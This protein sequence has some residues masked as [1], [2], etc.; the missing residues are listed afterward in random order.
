MSAQHLQSL[1][2]QAQD[3]QHETREGTA[4]DRFHRGNAA[5]AGQRSGRITPHAKES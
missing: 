4:M 3:R 5:G 2:E 1:H